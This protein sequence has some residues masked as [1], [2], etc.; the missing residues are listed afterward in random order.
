MFFKEEQYA[1]LR[2]LELGDTVQSNSVQLFFFFPVLLGKRDFLMNLE[3]I[4][5]FSR[6]FG[7]KFFVFCFLSWPSL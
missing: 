1:G 3:R 7:A 6:R 4:E 2:G 5:E